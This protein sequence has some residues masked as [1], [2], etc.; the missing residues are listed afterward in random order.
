MQS[1]AIRSAIAARAQTASVG[2]NASLALA[3]I[4]YGVDS[5]QVELDASSGLPSAETHPG[6]REVIGAAEIAMVARDAGTVG[7]VHNGIA[8]LEQKLREAEE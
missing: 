5:H 2:G 4:A 1:G 8:E 3:L 6:R 7:Y